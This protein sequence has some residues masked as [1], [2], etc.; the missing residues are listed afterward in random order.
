MWQVNFGL[1]HSLRCKSSSAML[2]QNHQVTFMKEK[3]CFW[4]C[5][6]GK[7]NLCY[8]IAL[9]NYELSIF[10]PAFGFFLSSQKVAAM[11][12]GYVNRSYIVL[13]R[14]RGMEGGG[15]E[16]EKLSQSIV[17]LLIRRENNKFL[18]SDVYQW[19][20]SISIISL[21]TRHTVS[22]P[23]VVGQ[24]HF[25][26]LSPCMLL[27]PKERAVSFFCPPLSH[28]LFFLFLSPLSLLTRT[29]INLFSPLFPTTYSLSVRPWPVQRSFFDISKE[30]LACQGGVCYFL[31][32]LFSFLLF[33]SLLLLCSW[34]FEREEADWALF[35]LGAQKKNWN[36]HCEF[37]P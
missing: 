31:S 18:R 13:F 6:H 10:C 26:V 34:S 3:N 9:F 36:T 25:C 12:P 32:F 21:A 2:T 17:K 29:S 15:G 4:V 16:R 22:Q 24:Y 8:N 23:L 19:V 7:N 27:S 37:E 14:S 20:S 28:S 5:S 35:K 1:W 33:F 11:G 30:W